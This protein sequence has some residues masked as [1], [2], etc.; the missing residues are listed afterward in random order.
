[1]ECIFSYTREQAIEDGV[2]F[3]VSKEMPELAERQGFKAPLAITTGVHSL[4]LVPDGLE[5]SQDYQGRLADVLF[6]AVL[7]FKSAEDKRLVTFKV[8]FQI[9]EAKKELVF[10]WMVFNEFEGFTILTP[11]EY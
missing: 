8:L 3:N 10:L 4:C 11:D 1:M 2:L 9:T 7:G 5:G 6:M